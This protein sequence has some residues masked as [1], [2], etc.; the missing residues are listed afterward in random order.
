VKDISFLPPRGQHV[1]P[2]RRGPRTIE[3]CPRCVVTLQERGGGK[4]IAPLGV[5]KRH[6]RAHQRDV[7]GIGTKA[8]RS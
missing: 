2:I 4:R 6:W 1:G 7:H 5:P 3:V 8:R